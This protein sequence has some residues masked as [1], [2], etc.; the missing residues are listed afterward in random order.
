MTVKEIVASFQSDESYYGNYAIAF[1]L[2]L[3]YLMT[4]DENTYVASLI[5]RS[6]IYNRSAYKCVGYLYY[7]NSVKIALNNIRASSTSVFSLINKEEIDLLDKK[8]VEEAVD[9]VNL[10]L[11]EI[12]TFAFN[13][14]NSLSKEQKEAVGRYTQLLRSISPDGLLDIYYT[15]SP[16]FF[17]WCCSVITTLNT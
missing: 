7:D 1:G 8:A 2:S 11:E 15:A 6:N 16:F 13:A 3:P 9:Q 4:S 5:Y 14:P 10:Y 12:R 17:D